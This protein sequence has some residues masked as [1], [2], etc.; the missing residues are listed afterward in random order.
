[1]SGNRWL[2]VS[3]FVFALGNGDGVR[4]TTVPKGSWPPF[5]V[6]KRILVRA[7]RSERRPRSC[8]QRANAVKAQIG[9]AITSNSKSQSLHE[10]GVSPD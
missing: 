10:A 9:I 5:S 1:M 8:V 2:L 4:G 3:V 6:S 7:M